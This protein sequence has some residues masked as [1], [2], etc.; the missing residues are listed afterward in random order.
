MSKPAEIL[1]VDDMPANLEVVMETL[2]SAGYEVAATTSGERALKR[3]QTYLPDLIL[4]DVQMPGIDGFETCRQ[5]KSNATTAEIPVIFITALSD[6]ESIAKGF[7]LGAVDYITKPFREVEVLARI[8]T[9]LDLRNLTKNLEQQVK[10]RTADLSEALQQLQS[11]QI[12]LVQN[13]KM[14]ALGNLMAGVAHEINNPIGFIGSNI[15]AAQEYLQDLLQAIAL[16]Q[17]NCYSVHTEL[18][19]ELERLDLE[20]IIEDFPKI[21]KSMQVGVERIC[22]IGTSLRIFSRTDTD[23]K[24]EFDLHEGINSTLSILKYRLKANEHRPA[25]EVVKNFG[26]IPEVKCYPGQ[27]NQ[28]FMNILANAID[29]L[30]ENTQN[31]SFDEIE[32]TPN[33]ITLATEL[34]EDRQTVIVKI[35]DN[36]MGMTEAVKAKIFEQGFTTKEVGKGTGLGMAIAA[37][38]VQEKHGGAIAC[39][40]ELGKGTEFTISLP[41]S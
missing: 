36:G 39:Q 12:Q 5:I 6:S 10:K 28:V 34:S 23:A 38:I 15:S 33:C 27:I 19:E 8:K 41:V 3:L 32:Q 17:Q 21:I 26:N 4:L 29:T 20:F 2:S 24:T 1:V 14:A 18:A 9:H 16:Y 35:M 13:E 40:S 37:Q 11:S 7:S 31:K 22:E 25:I 30:D